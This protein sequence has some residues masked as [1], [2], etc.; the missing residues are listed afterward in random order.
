MLFSYTSNQIIKTRSSDR[1]VH[2]TKDSLCVCVSVCTRLSVNMFVKQIE[3]V[4]TAIT[5]ARM[6]LPTY[7]NIQ[8]IS[9]NS[10]FLALP[11][12]DSINCACI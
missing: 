12:K 10:G 9:H 5:N 1:N 7:I 2:N 4:S 8:T 11:L 6:L 3:K